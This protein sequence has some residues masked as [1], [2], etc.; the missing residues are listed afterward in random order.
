MS[1]NTQLVNAFCDAWSGKDI[2]HL[3]SFFSDDAVYTNVPID[4]P[5]VGIDAIRTTCQGFIA[6]AGKIEWVRH[7][8]AENP[9]TGV[10][11]NERTDR[12]EIGG[13]WVEAKVMGVFELRDGKI[14]KWRDYFDLAQFQGQ[15]GG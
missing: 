15:L 13:K 5:N 4:P 11:M 14:A 3:M 2:D 12:F 6:M 1:Q 9:E 8:T 7:H 10:V